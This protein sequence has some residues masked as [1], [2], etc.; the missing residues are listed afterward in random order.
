MPPPPRPPVICYDLNCNPKKMST[1]ITTTTTK[2]HND[3]K[4]EFKFHHKKQPSDDTTLEISA[5]LFFDEEQDKTMLELGNQ[6]NRVRNTVEEL[7]KYPLR[8]DH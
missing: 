3:K 6:L 5:E 1:P 2:N 4:P 7:K 8:S